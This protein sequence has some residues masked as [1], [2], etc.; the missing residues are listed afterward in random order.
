MEVEKGR[1]AGSGQVRDCE[2][3]LLGVGIWK[4]GL[5]AACELRWNSL[6]GRRALV[7]NSFTDLVWW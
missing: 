2:A 4:V 5:S 7:R 3:K 6:M 1:G